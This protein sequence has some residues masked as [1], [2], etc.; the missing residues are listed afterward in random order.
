VVGHA[1]VAPRDAGIVGR[2]KRED[3]R[4]EGRNRDDDHLHG[5]SPVDRLGGRQNGE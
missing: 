2:A 3:Q 5:E 4:Q 1:L